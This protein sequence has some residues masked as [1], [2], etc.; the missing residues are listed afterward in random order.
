MEAF[1]E[2]GL[3]DDG[4]MHWQQP[5]VG[6]LDL[7]GSSGG[8]GGGGHNTNNEGCPTGLGGRGDGA[9]MISAKKVAI[10]DGGLIDAGGEGGLPKTN[11]AAQSHCGSWN[12]NPQTGGGGGSGG[13]VSIIA[14]SNVATKFVNV[15]G[16]P[17][18]YKQL[19]CMSGGGSP[20]S[21][22]PPH[23]NKYDSTVVPWAGVSFVQESGQK[24][25]AG[26]SGGF[27]FR[28]TGAEDAGSGR[29]MNT[30]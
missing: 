22:P 8:T 24:G 19:W 1:L 25:G 9:I 21:T 20:G 27:V 10:A 29:I 7:V 4:H 17:D 28:R 14:G 26:G 23:N 18:S 2:G 3:V 12:S 16:V 6:G 13:F 11:D 30:Y 5:R 15:D